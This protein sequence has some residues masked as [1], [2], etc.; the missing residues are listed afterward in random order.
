MTYAR[1]IQNEVVEYPVYEGEII[2]RYPNCSFP[3][4][5]DPPEGYFKVYDIPIP[6]V[7]YTKNV[8]EGFPKLK[9]GIWERNWIIT[10]ATQE[11]IAE[12]ISNRWQLVRE[13]RNKKL[14]D[15]DWTQL[16]DA[17]VDSNVWEVYRQEL[18]DVTNQPDPFNIVWPV[19]PQ[20]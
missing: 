18:R 5:F 8:N 20:V 2:L 11:E 13:Q 16:R 9:D 7:D 6:E 10:D 12:R 3:T 19:S 17:P 4:P 15:S 1:I 14:L